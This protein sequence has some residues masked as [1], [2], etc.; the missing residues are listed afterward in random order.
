MSKVEQDG[1]DPRS[2]L[3]VSLEVLLQQLK[4]KQLEVNALTEQI[5]RLKNRESAPS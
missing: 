3:S 5:E 1:E 4:Q 2:G